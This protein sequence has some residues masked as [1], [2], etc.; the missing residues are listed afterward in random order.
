VIVIE[1]SRKGLMGQELVR[2]YSLALG[3]HLY[4]IVCSAPSA[5]FGKHEPVFTAIVESF[6]LAG[7]PA[8]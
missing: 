2:Q 3:K 5:S 8:S 6:K 7:A 4:R 1:Y